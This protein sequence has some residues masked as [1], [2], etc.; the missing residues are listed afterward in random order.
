MKKISLITIALL[1]LLL[2]AC[3]GPQE[4]KITDFQKY[5]NLQRDP[6]KIRIEYADAENA[7]F[8][9]SYKS[10]VKEI[11]DILFNETTFVKGNKLAAGNNSSMTFVYQDGTEVTISLYRIDE[12]GSAYYY[13]SSNNTGLFERITQIGY[14]Y[15][16]LGQEPP[17]NSESQKPETQ[18]P[19]SQPPI[20]TEEEML[21]AFVNSLTEE[22]INRLYASYN[23]ETIQVIP[24]EEY[25]YADVRQR[26]DIIFHKTNETDI[27][28]IAKTMLDAMIQPLMQPEEGRYYTITKYRLEEQPIVQINDH[29][30]WIKII[31]GY[32]AFDGNNIVTFQEFIDSGVPV[33]DGMIKFYAEGGESSFFF[34][35]IKDGDVYRL[36][37]YSDCAAFLNK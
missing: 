9:I 37:R 5:Q 3:G 15:G 35:I 16:V 18:E 20:I 31:Q 11:V 32:Y 2:V 14:D 36:Q 22:D 28:K 29:V 25:K 7:T 33:V 1:A 26:S 8:D 23:S 21:M 4:K 27:Q 6:S 24:S 19:E 12:N 30:W 17:Q 34:L 10:T 13:R